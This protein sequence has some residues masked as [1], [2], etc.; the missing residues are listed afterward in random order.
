[1]VMFVKRLTRSANVLPWFEFGMFNI[2]EHFNGLQ[3]YQ[4]HHDEWEMYAR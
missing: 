4:G 1:M 3:Y 2:D